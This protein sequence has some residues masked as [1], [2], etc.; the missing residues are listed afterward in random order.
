MRLHRPGHFLSIN[1]WVEGA[2][3]GGVQGALVLASPC[4]PS[5][6]GK[7]MLVLPGQIS[8]GL[9]LGP[10]V[11][12]AASPAG[13]CI[14]TRTQ[15]HHSIYPSWHPYCTSA[16]IHLCSWASCCLPCET[17]PSRCLPA[18]QLPCSSSPAPV[19]QLHAQVGSYLPP[20]GAQNY[21]SL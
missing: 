10:Q 11:R 9:W 21:W 17:H 8:D 20:G 5:Q 16:S 12:R 15:M 7:E 1:L 2:V 3:G 18:S 4:G 6:G 14:L 19:I 13:G